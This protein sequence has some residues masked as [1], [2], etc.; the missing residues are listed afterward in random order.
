M[1]TEKGPVA[2]GVNGDAASCV[3]LNCAP[4][5]VKGS[6][7]K[8][9]ALSG[10]LCE[11]ASTTKRSASK[12]YYCVAVEIVRVA[13]VPA[14]GS[15]CGASRKVTLVVGAATVTGV[16]LATNPALEA[17]TLYDPVEVFVRVNCPVAFVV[18]VAATV[19]PCSSSIV[20]LGTALPN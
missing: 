2:G 14:D 9:D 7:L 5:D 19:A 11:L 10:I 6:M 12:V 20:A 16:E 13:T 15:D 1:A 3:K 18:S 17:R 8:A 4:L